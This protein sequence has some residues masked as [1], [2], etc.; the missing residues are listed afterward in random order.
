MER[1]RRLRK[2]SWIRDAITDVSISRANLVYP[3]FLDDVKSDKT[4]IT[5]MPG[6]YRWGK[7]SL[8]ELIATLKESRLQAV[9][10]FPAIAENDKDSQATYFKN[11][12]HILPVAIKELKDQLPELNIITDIA[13]DPYSSDG[14]DG[15]VKNGE[16][17]NDET[18]E[19]LQQMALQHAKWGADWVAPSDM[20]DGR[21]GAIRNALDESGYNMVGIISYCAKYASSLYGPFREALD[22]APKAGDKKTYQMNYASTKELSREILLDEQ[23]GADILMVKPAMLYLDVILKAHQQSMLPIAAYQV[24]GEYAMIHAAAKQGAFD[25]LQLA[26]ESLLAI[27]RA[28]ASLIF[29]YYAQKIVN[30]QFCTD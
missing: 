8:P 23:E 11:P 10:L 19:I 18:V 27:K 16:I 1:P 5:A 24:S 21:V 4:E 28:G 22:S 15:V 6:Q 2:N 29:T 30:S 12:D 9:A 3:L 26:A 13:L 25:E 17:L 14:H 7:N 20:M